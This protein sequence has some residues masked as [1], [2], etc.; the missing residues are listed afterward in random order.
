MRA[1]QNRTLLFVLCAFAL[2]SGMFRVAAA[3]RGKEKPAIS[4][5]IVISPVYGGGGNSGATLKND[6][7]ELFNLSASPVDVTGWSI[8]YGSA[9]GTSWQVTPLCPSGPCSIAPGHYFLIQE[10]QG[11]AGA[12]DLPTPN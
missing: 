11:S 6:F 12:N 2:L 1:F 10:A 4:T 8:Q 3:R 5:N 9:T 7:I